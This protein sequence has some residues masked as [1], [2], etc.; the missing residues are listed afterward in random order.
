MPKQKLFQTKPLTKR[1][2]AVLDILN[3]EYQKHKTKPYQKL[4]QCVLKQIQI[5]ERWANQ[6]NKQN[7]MDNNAQGSVT[8]NTL[9]SGVNRAIPDLIDRK[10]ILEV[11][12]GYLINNLHTRFYKYGNELLTQV[13]FTDP[14]MYQ[15]YEGAYYK[16]VYAIKVN[17]ADVDKAKSIF[18]NLLGSENLFSVNKWEDLVILLLREA[19]GDIAQE[20]TPDTES[21]AE[22]VDGELD[23][24]DTL[25]ELISDVYEQQQTPPEKKKQQRRKHT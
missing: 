7:Q 3:E 25:V 2:Q 10:A 14:D 6:Q 8:K 24:L 12:G 17:E 18:Y 15:T 22:T 21:N 5:A 4:G 19:K 13:R 11:D 23:L 9:K 16:G 20:S 1:E